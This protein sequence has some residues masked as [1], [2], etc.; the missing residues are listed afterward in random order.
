MRHLSLPYLGALVRDSLWA[1]RAR[2]ELRRRTRRLLRSWRLPGDRTLGMLHEFN[3]VLMGSAVLDLVLPGMANTYELELCCPKGGL[4][5][6]LGFLE[7]RGYFWST[8]DNAEPGAWR[9]RAGV[10]DVVVVRHR[11]NG[12]MIRVVESVAGSSLVPVLFAPSTILMNCV[13]ESGVVCLYPRL[14]FART[15]EVSSY[16]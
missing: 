15:G 16:G 1:V 4:E 11:N 3:C 12:R 9:P 7:S 13:T 6:P 5:G 10:E 8:E 14:A 2:R